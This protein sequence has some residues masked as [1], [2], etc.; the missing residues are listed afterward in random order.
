MI[1][2]DKAAALDGLALGGG[3]KITRVGR[4][5]RFNEEK[6]HFFFGHGPML[7]TFRHHE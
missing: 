3:R 2:H 6:M 5:G 7:D 1:N 4:S